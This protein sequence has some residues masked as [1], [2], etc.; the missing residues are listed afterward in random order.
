MSLNL[1][2]KKRVE[3]HILEL[4]IDKNMNRKLK[5]LHIN[6]QC[7]NRTTNG[8][9]MGVQD[10]NIPESYDIDKTVVGKADG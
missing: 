7:T 1:K 10:Y 6:K 3:G 4:M 2:R 5:G 8:T 9:K